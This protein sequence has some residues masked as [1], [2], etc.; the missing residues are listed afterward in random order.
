[1]SELQTRMEILKSELQAMYPDRIVTRSLVGFDQRKSE[2]LKKGIYT[3]VSES[4]SDLD[5]ELI[6]KPADDPMHKFILV[7]QIQIGEKSAHEEIENAEGVFIDE[8][9]A[10]VRDPVQA[11]DSVL[12]V[13]WQQSMQL[14]HPYGWVRF[15]LMMSTPY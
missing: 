15:N 5:N 6:S 4:A 12:L 8:V 13:G 11:L 10:W 2:D 7:G 3:F 1:M 9:L 14:D